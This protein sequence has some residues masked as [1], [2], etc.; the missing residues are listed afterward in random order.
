MNIDLSMRPRKVRIFEKSVWAAMLLLFLYLP[1][2]FFFVQEFTR[3]SISDKLMVG[4]ILVLV[5]LV[6]L[7][8]TMFLTYLITRRKS[9]IMY[10]ITVVLWLLSTA[11][12]AYDVGSTLD[13]FGLWLTIAFLAFSVWQFTLLI[14]KD[15][16]EWIYPKMSDDANPQSVE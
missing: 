12:S 13:A 11:L 10:V 5:F 1:Y 16:R 7:W 8:I 3:L 9:K 15:F 4:S 6:I 2:H 14:S